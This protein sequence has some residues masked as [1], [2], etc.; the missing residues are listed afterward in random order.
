MCSSRGMPI[1]A[2]VLLLPVIRFCEQHR[3]MNNWERV[4]SHIEAIEARRVIE[5]VR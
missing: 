1:A 2:D 4:V 5:V 3:R